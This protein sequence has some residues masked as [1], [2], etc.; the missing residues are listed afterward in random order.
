MKQPLLKQIYGAGT[1]VKFVRLLF[2]MLK[3]Q[4]GKYIEFKNT[5]SKSSAVNQLKA[6]QGGAQKAS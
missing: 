2:I 6:K 1:Q 3:K 5:H 4:V